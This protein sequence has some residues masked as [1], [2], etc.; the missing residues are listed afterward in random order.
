MHR[1][2][3]QDGTPVILKIRRPGI[4]AKIAA[5][6]RILAQLAEL[7]ESEITEARRYQPTQIAAQFARSLERELD[8]ALEARNIEHF[9]RNFADD[10]F[11][12]IPKAFTAW[13]SEVMNVQAHIEGIPGTDLAGVQAAGLDR[14]LLA[15]RGAEAV[16]RMILV[17]GFFHADPHPGNVFYLPGNRIV[18]IDFGMVGRLSPTRRNQVVDLLAGL[19]QMDEDAMIE[20]LL[21]WAGDAYVDELKLAADVNELVY[22]YES[23][24]LK[25]IRIAVLLRQFAAIIREHSIVLPPDLTLMF[26]ALITMEGL[27]RQYDP[28]FHIVEHLTP[29]LHQALRAR[30]RPAA[31]VKRGRSTLTGF[32]NVVG[33]VPRDLARLLREARRGKTRIDLDLKRLDDFGRQLDRTL[34]RATM[35]VMTASLVIGS[36]IIMTI[37]GG[38]EMMGIPLLGLLGLTGYV[39]AFVNSIWII[40]GIWRAGKG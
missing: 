5:D 8:L 36:A 34:D 14:K 37:S 4:R 21:D 26:K 1:A 28:G 32:L 12:V 27:G 31:V 35:G 25:D 7:I 24:P 2:R 33:S 19:A 16:L 22:D 6:L 13:T 11:I 20:V 10:P 29:L 39:V 3:L 17:D 40:I 38:P 18:M 30:Y 15:A 9:A 23:V